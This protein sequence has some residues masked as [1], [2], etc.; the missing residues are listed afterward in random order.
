MTG[1]DPEKNK[2]KERLT[3]KKTWSDLGQENAAVNYLSEN[4]HI[5]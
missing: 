5:A 4:R 3:S 1:S 2:N